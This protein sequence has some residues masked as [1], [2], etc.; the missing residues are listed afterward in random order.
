[1]SSARWCATK[2]ALFFGNVPLGYRVIDRKL[3]ADEA[4]AATVRHIFTRYV[5]LGS[6]RALLEEL[7]A[8]GY[9]TKLNPLKDGSSR[10]GKPFTRDMLF[11]MLS[12]RIYIGDIVHKGEAHRGEHSAIVD[13]ELWSQVQATLAAKKIDHRL[14]TNV[15]APSLLTGVLYDAYDRRSSRSHTVKGKKRYR[16]Y[17]THANELH[18]GEPATCRMPAHEPEH[19]VLRR[20]GELLRG[21]RSIPDLA[22]ADAG[23][24]SLVSRGRRRRPC[25]SGQAD[26]PSS[27]QRSHL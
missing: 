5:A 17:V 11:Q 20:L 8:D 24:A 19:T 10:G 22:T 1:M 23:D 18:D 15:Q 9:R 26:F 6:E 4:E 2:A 16:Y 21:T 12:S 13:M 7:R 3:I 25:S 14:G 27:S